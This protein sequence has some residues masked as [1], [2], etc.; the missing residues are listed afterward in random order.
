MKIY[1]VNHK[2]MYPLKNLNRDTKIIL[3]NV[4]ANRGFGAKKIVCVIFGR[5]WKK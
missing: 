1:V 3:Q 2:E 5:V 4:A